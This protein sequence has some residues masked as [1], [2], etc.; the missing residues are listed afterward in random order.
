MD[1][2][3]LISQVQPTPQEEVE[4]SIHSDNATDFASAA[5][6]STTETAEYMQEKEPG[7]VGSVMDRITDT[8]SSASSSLGQ[9]ARD[10]FGDG[11]REARRP[12]VG[13]PRPTIYGGN[14]FFDVTENDLVKEM[15]RFGA[16]VQC[17]LIRDS[18][19]LS[20]G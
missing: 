20:K 5:K 7:T 11:K 9:A 18:R 14:L 2:D 12:L 8:F 1:Q 16:I 17:R 10:T 15:S 13:E 3:A 4:N 6:P 19:G